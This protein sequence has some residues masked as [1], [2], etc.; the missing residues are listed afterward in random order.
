MMTELELFKMCNKDKI[1]TQVGDG[2]DYGFIEDSGEGI[3]YIFFEPSD[4][5]DDWRNNFS[6]WRRPYKDMEISYRVHGGFLKCWKTVEDIIINKILEEDPMENGSYRWRRIVVVGYSHGGA[7][8]ALCHE[9]V[10]FHRGDLRQGDHILG[11]GFEAPRIYAGW[12]LPQ[13]LK[14][15]W[16]TFKVYRNKNDIVTHMPPVCFFFR[17]VGE[18]VKIGAESACGPIEAHYRTWVRVGLGEKIENIAAELKREK[19]WSK[20]KKRARAAEK[21]KQRRMRKKSN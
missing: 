11:Y 15:R 6:Y 21:A 3:L 8:A 16:R 5:L 7:L 2:V 17:H 10:W 20:Q 13:K 18:I 4:G 14:E 12:R 19:E 1:Y 9:C